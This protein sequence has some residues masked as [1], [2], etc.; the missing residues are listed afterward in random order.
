MLLFES[1][2]RFQIVPRHDKNWKFY[3]FAFLSD[4]C[5][6]DPSNNVQIYSVRLDCKWRTM[7][8]DVEKKDEIFGRYEI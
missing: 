2:T 3:V 8:V 1:F 5:D 4:F 7:I 6:D